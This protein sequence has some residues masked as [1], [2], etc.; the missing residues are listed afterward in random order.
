MMQENSN[1]W[2][3]LQAMKLLSPLKMCYF[4]D[5]CISCVETV[6]GSRSKEVYENSRCT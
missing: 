2:L 4:H 6:T 3:Y 5:Q 1:Y